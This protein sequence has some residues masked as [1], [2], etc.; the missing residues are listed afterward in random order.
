VLTYPQPYIDTMVPPKVH[1]RRWLVEDFHK[2]L[3][4]PD[5]PYKDCYV[6]AMTQCK[7]PIFEAY[8]HEY[9]HLLICDRGYRRWTRIIAERKRRDDPDQVI[10][11]VWPWIR[12]SFDLRAGDGAP[13]P[14]STI[15]DSGFTGG[16]DHEYQTAVPILLRNVIFKPALEIRSVANVLVHIHRKSSVYSLLSKNCYWYAGSVYEALKVLAGPTKEN[17]FYSLESMNQKRYVLYAKFGLQVS[18]GAYPSI[19]LIIKLKHDR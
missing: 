11:G 8:L 2:E 7:N 14:G 12:S 17:V 15:L 6:I 16:E 18:F 13:D 4:R 5:S 10:I 1:V 3:Q 19:T 9:I